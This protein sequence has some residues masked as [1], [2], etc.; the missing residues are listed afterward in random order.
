[1]SSKDILTKQTFV[2]LTKNILFY[3]DT[4]CIMPLRNQTN[5]ILIPQWKGRL[6]Q[7][8]FVTS[9]PLQSCHLTP[10]YCH[11][12][13]L[14]SFSSGDLTIVWHHCSLLLPG[15]QE[16]TEQWLSSNCYYQM[17]EE[18]EATVSSGKYILEI[19]SLF[20]KMMGEE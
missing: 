2:C 6:V 17:F 13:I 20:F 7:T 4:T 14:T 16:A 3:I 1:M 12:W 5:N 15:D 9:A 10:Y 11:L 19:T 18:V 8:A